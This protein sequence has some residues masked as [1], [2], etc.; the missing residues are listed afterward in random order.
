MHKVVLLSEHKT[1]LPDPAL[2]AT[3]PGGIPLVVGDYAVGDA[4][5]RGTFGEVRFG[6]HRIT[7]DK[8]VL[9][10]AMKPPALQGLDGSAKANA[11]VQNL[12]SLKQMNIV[13][14][15]AREDHPNC[16]VFACEM[17]EGGDMHG[18]LTS[19]GPSVDDAA[20][21]DA[22]A[23]LVMRQLLSAVSFAHSK[24]ILHRDLKLENV[25]LAQ[26]GALNTVKVGDFGLCGLFS[27]SGG[28]TFDGLGTLYI[29]PPEAMDDK[30]S[31]ATGPHFDVWALGVLLFTMLC[32]RLPFGKAGYNIGADD[33]PD[34]AVVKSKIKAGAYK[35]SAGVDP[36]AADL[37]RWMLALL[38]SNR[39]SITEAL[40]HPWMTETDLAEATAAC[41]CPLPAADGDGTTRRTN[42]GGA[43]TLRSPSS[44]TLLGASISAVI[45]EKN[46]ASSIGV[47]ALDRS[48]HERALDR[49]NHGLSRTNLGESGISTVG[50]DSL[51]KS[52]HEHALDRSNHGL[53]HKN[54]NSHMMETGVA[55]VTGVLRRKASTLDAMEAEEDQFQRLAEAAAKGGKKLTHAGMSSL[56][57]S[58]HA[59]S[60][61]RGSM[62]LTSRSEHTVSQRRR[63]PSFMD[64]TRTSNTKVPDKYVK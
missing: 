2:A 13:H 21:T 63:A 36:L 7:N 32:G 17:L 43:P 31:V 24:N 50:T 33:P 12:L 52:I 57:N 19:R 35:L 4:I 61:R 34:P 5:G 20:L 14:V 38:P 45:S 47:D 22:E 3:G 26:K 8:V 37:L 46:R 23:R 18:F 39:A 60:E 62:D 15:L 10:F 11:V 25:F 53:S 27:S 55:V 51:D 40:N 29:L 1:W 30:K 59:T 44:K 16:F 56:N 49:S 58:T 48:I 9:K 42:R 41:M 28:Q 6:T 64:T 54:S